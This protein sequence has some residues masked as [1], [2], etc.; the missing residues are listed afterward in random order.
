[1]GSAFQTFVLIVA[2][3]VGPSASAISVPIAEWLSSINP[4]LRQ[5]AEPLEARGYSS[6]D[7]F[8]KAGDRDLAEVFEDLGMK[9]PHRRLLLNGR[10]VC[11]TAGSSAEQDVSIDRK[12][13]LEGIMDKAQV[14]QWYENYALDHPKERGLIKIL[15]SKRFAK[16]LL[17]RCEG[18]KS[19]PRYVYH[20]PILNYLGQ[21][22]LGDQNEDIEALIFCL[23][24]ADMLLDDEAEDLVGNAPFAVQAYH[25]LP[26]LLQAVEHTSGNVVSELVGR[27]A[28]ITSTYRHPDGRST[29]VTPLHAVLMVRAA[30]SQAPC[31]AF[32]IAMYVQQPS[33]SLCNLFTQY[34][35]QKPNVGAPHL[36]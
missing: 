28:N 31:S 8:M 24:D 26:L 14:S 10:S 29:G 21:F 33:Q 18:G 20:T 23:L 5:Y 9:K 19:F 3:I 16:K 15:G 4:S 34:R 35:L 12:Y 2:C 25:R 36:H 27:G 6:S 13:R 32:S 11:D 30:P 1:M 7:T 17:K 22:L